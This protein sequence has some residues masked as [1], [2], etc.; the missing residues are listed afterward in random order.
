MNS[1]SIPVQSTVTR[2]TYRKKGVF[3]AYDAREIRV[4]H[5]H[6][7]DTRQ[8]AGLATGATAESSWLGPQA[9]SR[10]RTVNGGS[11]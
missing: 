5:Q 11:L 8:Q 1:F 7:E 10:E 3:G 2:A 6:G 9:G 4:H